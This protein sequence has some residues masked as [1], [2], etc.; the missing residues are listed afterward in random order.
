[1]LVLSHV[2]GLSCRRSNWA[3]LFERTGSASHDERELRVSATSAICRLALNYENT[4][5]MISVGRPAL[6]KAR[7]HPR[8]SLGLAGD[9]SHHARLAAAD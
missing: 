5:S 9:M 4:E 6:N 8:E 2:P 3:L 7:T 1:M